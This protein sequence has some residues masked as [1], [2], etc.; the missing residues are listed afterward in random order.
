MGREIERKFLVR[1]DT[2]R[3]DVQHSMRLRQAYLGEG[4]RASIRVRISDL[5]AIV[6]IKSLRVSVSRQEYEYP[7]PVADAEELFALCSDRP[8]VKTRH[9]VVVG[10]HTWEIDEFE[11]ANAGLVVAEIELDDPAERFTRP[12]WLGEEVSDD[13][14]YYNASLART[15]YCEWPR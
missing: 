10:A 15:P 13:G 5:D 1:D 8:V 3:A 12:A 2:W 4:E 9:L 7:I 6:N 14:R 11:G